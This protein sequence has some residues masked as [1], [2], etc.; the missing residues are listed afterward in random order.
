MRLAAMI[1]CTKIVPNV[2]VTKV[3]TVCRTGKAPRRAIKISFLIF[4]NLTWKI[5]FRPQTPRLLL[6]LPLPANL[7][8]CLL[9]FCWCR[10]RQ[11]VALY[12][13]PDLAPR[14]QPCSRSRR[15]FG[16]FPA[17]RCCPVQQVARS[18]SHQTTIP[19][20]RCNASSQNCT[21]PPTLPR[22]QRCIDHGQRRRPYLRRK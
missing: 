4:W 9:V 22:L 8:H 2:E 12:F 3:F 1:Q 7:S 16:F 17:V 21:S 18:K 6:D 19:R 20:L 13:P 15:S 14:R 11:D 10:C 5:I